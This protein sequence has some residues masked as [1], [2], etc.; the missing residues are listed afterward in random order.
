[1]TEVAL[2]QRFQLGD[3]DYIRPVLE[4]LYAECYAADR[5][6]PF[7]ATERFLERL[8]DHAGAGWE[9]TVAYSRGTPAGY[10][11]GCPL[12]VDTVWWDGTAP[13]S[14]MDSAREDG[15]RT[16]AVLQLMVRA[17]W[18]GT[19][20]ARRLHDDLLGPRREKRATLLVESA[21]TKVRQLYEQWGYTAVARSH[22]YRDGPTYDIMLRDHLPL[23]ASP[24]RHGQIGT[25]RQRRQRGA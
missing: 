8:S 23:I 18:R 16:F 24:S 2:V 11:Y 3:L 17:E 21:H 19:G 25:S 6:S 22:P 20:L 10:A 5:D 13:D 12:P 14:S 4:Q 15:H 7:F 1:M 9:A